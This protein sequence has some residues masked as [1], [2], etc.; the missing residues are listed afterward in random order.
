[1]FPG[2]LTA[3]YADL[4]PGGKH[5]VTDSLLPRASTVHNNKYAALALRNGDSAHSLV[6]GEYTQGN[7]WLR[8]PV[9]FRR[10]WPC[11]SPS[12]WIHARLLSFMAAVIFR[13]Q[14]AETVPL[15]WFQPSSSS[16]PWQ[17][18]HATFC[19]TYWVLARISSE[20]CGQF[21][22]MATFST[23]GVY[24]NEKLQ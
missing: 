20:Q 11:E 2:R 23:A 16:G 17:K 19:P 18:R 8:V 15:V 7:R 6:L 13:T 1:M 14:S 10:R 24:A 4:W 22:Y 21:V 3:N 12:P 9:T 5:L